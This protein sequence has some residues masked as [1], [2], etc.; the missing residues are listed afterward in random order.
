MASTPLYASDG[1]AKGQVELPEEIFNID[2]NQPVMHQALLRQLANGRQ[3]GADTKTRGEVRGGGRKP[4]R[5]KGTGR[6]RHGS[7]REP[8]WVG[9][10]TAF[11]PHPRSYRQAMP[12]RMRRL[13]LRSALSVKWREGSVA[14]LEEVRLEEPRTKLVLGLF[15][16]MGLE[17]KV[18]VV[19]AAPSYNLQRSVHN[20][21]N[22]KA[23]LARNLN[24]HDLL[25]FD[26][27]VMLGEAVAQVQEVLP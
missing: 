23:I 22:V 10:G 5:Q 1:S 25:T 4:W 7:T 20:L 2:P 24:L 18:L 15:H 17:G 8:S 19:L 26:H 12:R 6:A 16:A 9:G 13:A 11:G 14:V 3:G 27:V 21:P